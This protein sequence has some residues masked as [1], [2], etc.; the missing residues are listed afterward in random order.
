MPLSGTLL[1]IARFTPLYGYVSLARR[2]I[3]EGYVM[4]QQGTMP[5]VEPLW[6]SVTNLVVWGVIFAVV[7]V[8]LVRRS[9]GRQ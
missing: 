1:D 8:L 3:T 4:T 2:P 6:I 9:R 7:A 5:E